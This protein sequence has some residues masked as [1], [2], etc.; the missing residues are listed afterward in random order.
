MPN[1]SSEIH[2]QYAYLEIQKGTTL[3]VECLKEIE[4][5]ATEAEKNSKKLL[6][7][8]PPKFKVESARHFSSLLSF[9]KKKM[10]GKM[11]F[12]PQESLKWS[13]EW[14]VIVDSGFWVAQRRQAIAW[15]TA[16]K[17]ADPRLDSIQFGKIS[18]LKFSGSYLEKSPKFSEVISRY[19]GNIKGASEITLPSM[20]QHNGFSVWSFLDQALVID[21]SHVTAVGRGFIAEL[22]KVFE[23][24]QALPALNGIYFLTSENFHSWLFKYCLGVKKL[25]EVGNIVRVM[26]EREIGRAH[27]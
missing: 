4:T 3:N 23:K 2:E 8:L 27:V 25:N 17:L 20:V 26:P 9:L 16:Q 24:H 10:G 22:K 5:F 12:V 1:T 14:G 11:L 15:A 21:V 13:K 19:V 7:S 6:L 18:Y